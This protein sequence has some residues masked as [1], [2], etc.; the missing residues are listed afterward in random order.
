MSQSSKRPW[1]LP[2][3]R[4]L[5]RLLVVTAAMF[6][7][8]KVTE[9][10]T[11]AHTFAALAHQQDLAIAAVAS[12]NPVEIG[13]RFLCALTPSAAEM[14]R[15]DPSPTYRS[16]VLPGP[17]DADDCAYTL[18]RAAPA[19]G[20]ALPP[21]VVGHWSDGLGSFVMPFVAMLDTGWHLAVQPSLFASIFS[22]FAFVVGAFAALIALAMWDQVWRTPL[23]TMLLAVGAIAF[24]CIVAFLLREIM[25]GGLY[26]FG[27]ITHFA[28]FCCG[29]SSVVVIAYQYVVKLFETGIHE[30]VEHV[31]PR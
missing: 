19:P 17:S 28:G 30:G 5:L 11:D 13:S 22:L 26:L 16:H 9:K 24:A 1:Y 7:V 14:R 10:L 23:A 15:K 29:A 12:I 31:L 18:S 20:A 25:E 4:F 27:G 6:A 8:S 3:P 2:T 21:P